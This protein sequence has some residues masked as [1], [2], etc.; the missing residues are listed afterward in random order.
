MTEDA[1]SRT[2]SKRWDWYLWPPVVYPLLWV[3][4]ALALRIGA[5]PEDHE[6]L[7]VVLFWIPSVVCIY[8]GLK[9]LRGK[10]GHRGAARV[11]LVIWNLAL[12]AYFLLQTIAWMGMTGAF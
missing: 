2:T 6:A 9:V 11:F 12:P 7:S 3:L 8:A 1:N 5:Y 4:Q 10:T